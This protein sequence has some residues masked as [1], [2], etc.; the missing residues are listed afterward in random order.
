MS[1]FTIYP[2]IDLREG[3][4]VRL[5]QGDPDRETAYDTQPLA[6]ARRWQAGASTGRASRPAT[7]P[8]AAAR[9]PMPRPA[10]RR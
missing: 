10:C 7:W 9:S 4:V 2:A 8:P 1:D 6:V 3:R 5:A